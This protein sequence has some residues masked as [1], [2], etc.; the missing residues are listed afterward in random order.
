VFAVIAGCSFAVSWLFFA[1]LKSNQHKSS[2]SFSLVQM[3]LCNCGDFGCVVS[4][5]ASE[6]AER[7]C[8]PIP[9]V[10]PGNGVLPEKAVFGRK[11]VLGPICARIPQITSQIHTSGAFAAGPALRTSLIETSENSA[12][13][14]GSSR[15][16]ASIAARVRLSSKRQARGQHAFERAVPK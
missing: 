9:E 14:I 7:E 10:N 6:R 4:H 12:H 16:P 11:W 15:Q 1:N 2:R 8:G 13:L 3:I 5:P